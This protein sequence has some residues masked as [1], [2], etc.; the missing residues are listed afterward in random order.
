MNRKLKA[1]SLA[2]IAVFAM[3]AISATTASAEE[4]HAGEAPGTVKGVNVGEEVFTTEAGTVTCKIAEYNG[5]FSTTTVKTQKV[6]PTYKE[7][8][9]FG[10]IETP[11]DVPTSCNYEFT[12]PV[13]K[14]GKVNIVGCTEPI[15]VT[16]SNCWVTIGNQNG[17]SSVTY[18][19]GESKPVHDLLLHI[20]ITGIT[21]TQ[22]SKLFPG[23]KSGTFTNGKYTGTN[24]VR[25]YNAEGVQ[26]PLTVE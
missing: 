4:F 20:S 15:T 26:V 24:T 22:H 12:E 9:A 11:I 13:S 10:F 17:L 14:V 16:A 5:S 6:H 8:T 3:A 19:T 1:V 18:T 2:L 23:C 7:C 21:Y 25:A